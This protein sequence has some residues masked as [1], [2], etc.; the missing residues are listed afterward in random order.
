[1]GVVEVLADRNAQFAE[2]TF[3]RALQMKW[4]LATIVISYARVDP[5][6]VLGAAPG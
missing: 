5:A 6:V 4:T 3:D 2:T 1:M